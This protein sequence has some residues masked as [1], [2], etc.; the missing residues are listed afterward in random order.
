MAWLSEWWRRLA[1]LFHRGQ[2]DRDLE[3]EMQFHL[4]MQAEENRQ[5]GIPVAESRYAARRQFGNAMLLKETSDGVWGWEPAQRLVQDLKY[6]LRTLRRDPGFTAIAVFSLA[7]A[8]GA[9]TAIFSVVDSVLLRPLPYREPERLVTVS[10]DGSITAPLFDAFR[11][12]ARSIEQ[13]ALFVNWSFNLAGEGEPQRVPAARVSA[14]LFD[15]LGIQPLL[16]RAFTPD[17]DRSGH[18]SV[19]LISQGLWKRQ[20]GSDSRVLGR[21]VILNGAP[22]TIIGVM[23]AGFQFPD[24]PELPSFVGPFP[25]AQMWR[26]MALVDWERTCDGCFNFGM[27]A[28]LRRGIPPGQARAELNAIVKRSMPSGQSSAHAPMVTLRTLEDSVTG[29]V[30]TPVLILFGA[31]ALALLIACVNVANLLLARGLRRRA[32]IAIRLSLGASATRII[33]Q[34]LTEA[35]G[36]ALCA[37]ALA[38]PIA[39]LGSRALVAV[40]PAGLPRTESVALDARVLAF[41]FGL[42]LITT[43]LFGIAPALDSA[44]RAPI[45]A[46]KAETRGAT[47]APSRLRKA[48]VIAEFALSLVLLISASLLARSFVNVSSTPLGFHAENVL[49]MR[50]SLPDTKYDDQRRTALVEQ[51]A[52]NCSVLPGVTAAAAVSTLPL[53]GESEGWGWIAED[54]PNPNDPKSWTVMRA[55]AITP[56][57]FRTLGIRLRAGREFTAADRGVNPVAI[58]SQSAARRVWP[59]VANPVGRRFK[60]NPPVTVVGIVDDTRASGLDSEVKPY[61]YVPFWQFSPQEF[62]LAVRSAA[63]PA[64]LTTAVKSEIWRLDKELPVTHV[65]VMKQL[66]ADSI[67]SRRF[68]AEIMALFA[69][70]ALVLATLGIY[71]IVSYSVAQRTHE[72]GIRIA[73]GASRNAI[74]GAVVKEAGILAVFGAGLGLAGAFVLT[75]LLRGL[76]YGVD[77]AEPSTFVACAALLMVVALIACLIPARHATKINPIEALRCE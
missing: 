35:L 41:A 26:P 23:P 57:Y 15:L 70:F 18:E 36:L 9:T 32:E 37:A 64:R 27:I 77:V 11:R 3:E 14:G 67:A 28:R 55:R 34:L 61:I 74:L 12:E 71:G 4:D 68:Q 42:T 48:L 39:G 2:F 43:L 75:P 60:Q 46:M 5:S 6:A 17:E 53:T 25:P 54:N 1:V 58:V 38:I 33:R 16:G 76:L 8:I 52:A 10:L 62:A 45:D 19:V 13:A 56:S 29:K 69:G 21:K 66:V 20:F 40:A 51:F 65:A 24:G 30:R 44:R 72:I 22:H 31:V 7:L 73:L 50:L 59:G 49:T 63:D 47:Q